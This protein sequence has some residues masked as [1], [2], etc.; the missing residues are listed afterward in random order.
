MVYEP[1]DD[2]DD[3]P[4]LEILD[5]QGTPLYEGLDFDDLEEVPAVPEDLGL[6]DYE[7]L[8]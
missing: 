3:V 8:N 2:E 7:D 5:E 1:K 4:A 6:G